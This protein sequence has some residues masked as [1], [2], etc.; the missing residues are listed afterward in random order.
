[1]PKIKENVYRLPKTDH[2]PGKIHATSLHVC[3]SLITTTVP[4][5]LFPVWFGRQ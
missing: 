3:H 5:L 2:L 4:Y 1:M